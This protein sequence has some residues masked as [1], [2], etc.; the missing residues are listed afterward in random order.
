VYSDAR[1][2]RANQQSRGMKPVRILI[3]EDNIL[4]ATLLEEL[5]V[6]MGYEVCAMTTNEPDTI[7]AA[8]LHAPDL[9]IVDAELRVGSGMSAVAEIMKSRFVPYIF[10]TGDCYRV[11]RSIPDAIVLQKPYSAAALDQAIKRALQSA[12]TPI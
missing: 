4:I 1:K 10:A 7:A 8:A 2:S 9:M 5:L 12:A 11:L 3:A 6:M